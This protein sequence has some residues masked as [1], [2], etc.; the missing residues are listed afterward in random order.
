MEKSQI[1]SLYFKPLMELVEQA[2]KIHNKNFNSYLYSSQQA[3]L[4]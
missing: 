2:H 1:Q 4:H 3:A